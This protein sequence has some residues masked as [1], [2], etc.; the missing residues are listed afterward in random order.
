M[1]LYQY[2]CDDC[3][4]FEAWTG[5]ERANAPCLCPTC[6]A[7]SARELALPGLNSMN[8]SLRKALVRSEKSS[9]EPRVVS[10]SHLANCGCRLCSGRN[11]PQPLSRRW[12][13][14]H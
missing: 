12:M 2:A 7:A 8:G 13:I 6:G 5:M 4:S 14:G 3:G 1:P 9:D 10:R 11:R